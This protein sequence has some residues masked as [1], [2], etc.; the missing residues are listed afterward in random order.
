M[1]L[2]HELG[3]GV[4]RRTLSKPRA[5]GVRVVR[6][7]PD[8][9]RRQSCPE[10]RAATDIVTLV[11]TRGDLQEAARTPIRATLAPMRQR[12]LLLACALAAAC[13]T[14][15]TDTAHPPITEA[16]PAPTPPEPDVPQ[17]ITPPTDAQASLFAEATN[18]FALDLWARV[19]ETPGNQVVS[20]ASIAIALDM[21][22]GGARG[23]TAAEMARVLHAP[24]DAAALHEA[25]GNVLSTWNDPARESYTLAVANR[26][27]G[28]RAFTF[29]SSFVALTRDRYRAPVEPLDFAGAPEPARVHIND[30]VAAQTRD[31][32]RDLIPAGAIVA[33]T[34]L[35][36]TNAVYFLARWILPF[37]RAFTRDAE[38]FANG[39]ERVEVPTMH[40][41]GHVR[42]AE[43]ESAQVLELAYRGNEIA[44][45]IVLPREQG[46][47]A[48]LEAQLDAAHL[49]SFTSSLDA[50]H[51]VAVSLPK[52]R[53]APEP[54]MRLREPL[55]ALGMPLA[56]ARGSA[57][58][59]GI[60][61]PPRPDDRLY[62]AEVFHKAFVQVD[63][64]GTEAAAATAVVMARAGAAPPRDTPI[65]FT[66]DHPFLFFIRDV[67]SGAILFMGR[68]VD[69]SAG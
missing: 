34:R 5:A 7:L 12:A 43:T 55:R 9:L 28:E 6:S 56:F 26:L 69:P 39:T 23:D 18:A 16:Q 20:P 1:T 38:F 14:R 24:D 31:R 60:A 44:M 61:N 46:G 37:E 45:T 68:V 50:S 17:A 8:P 67:R 35:V 49:A 66:A 21:T 52:F 51:R 32:I 11:A 48:A 30:W 3:S 15:N 33:D 13:G 65:P 29:E 40:L 64:E 42:Y 41:V 62:I 22:Y 53:V 59:S 54:S 2:L 63:E 25:A 47:L 58:F 4:V 57:D 27:F 10:R 36:L 19:R